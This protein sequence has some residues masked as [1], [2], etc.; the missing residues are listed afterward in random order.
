MLDLEIN[1]RRTAVECSDG[2]TL[3]HLLRA[4]QRLI[5]TRAGCGLEQ[6]GACR[7]LINGEPAFACTIAA[8][9]CHGRTVETI[10]SEDPCLVRLREAFLALNAGQCGFCLSGILMSALHLLRRNPA[11]E[12]SDVQQALDSHLCRCGAHN[13]I[14]DAVLAAAAS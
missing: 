2:A 10:E 11:P 1:G 7:V 13:R 8:E 3:L 9:D 12:R 6:C 4:E 5:G 14:I